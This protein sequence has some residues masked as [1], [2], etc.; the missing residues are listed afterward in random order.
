MGM[1]VSYRSTL[2]QYIAMGEDWIVRQRLYASQTPVKDHPF[3]SIF[4]CG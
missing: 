1:H 2:C 3:S 4:E